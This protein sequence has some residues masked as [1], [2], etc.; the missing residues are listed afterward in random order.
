MRHEER[1]GESSIGPMLCYSGNI[2]LNREPNKIVKN[3][4]KTYKLNNVIVPK[5]C[6]HLVLLKKEI[7]MF[8]CWTCTSAEEMAK[9]L[10]MIINNLIK[11]NGIVADGYIEWAGKKRED[12]GVIIINCNDIS[13]YDGKI[14]Y[15]RRHYYPAFDEQCQP[16]ADKFN[17]L[18]SI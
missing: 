13:I 4:F 11:T 2:G 17:E 6:S 5:E 9:N 7:K 8:N 16:Q 18:H 3:F 1:I 12:I 14:Q 10:K 15:V